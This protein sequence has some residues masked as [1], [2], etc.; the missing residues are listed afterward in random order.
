MERERWLT[1]RRVEVVGRERR[2]YRIHA[3]GRRVLAQYRRDWRLLSSVLRSLG[4]LHA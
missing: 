1:S 2:Y 4:C 3:P